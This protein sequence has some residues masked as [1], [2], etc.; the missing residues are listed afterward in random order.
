MDPDT[1]GF[2]VFVKRLIRG[3][4][5]EADARIRPGDLLVSLQDRDVRGHGLVRLREHILG[6]AGSLARMGLLSADGAFYTADVVRG[7]YRE[8]PPPAPAA[9]IQYLPPLPDQPL[10]GYYY[11]HGAPHQTAPPIQPATVAAALRCPAPPQQRPAMASAYASAGSAPRAPQAH[12]DYCA[13]PAAH[14]AFR[15]TGGPAA[16][17][18]PEASVRPHHAVSRPVEPWMQPPPR[19]PLGRPEGTPPR[20][21]A[22]PAPQRRSPGVAGERFSPG[23]RPD[24]YLEHG[25][26]Q[27]DAQVRARPAPAPR[28]A[29]SRRVSMLRR[30][31]RGGVG[32]AG[33]ARHEA[34]IA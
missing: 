33:N 19:R 23:R 13:G 29:P 30:A 16:R 14:A 27:H 8:A 20:P 6:P 11:T 10:A 17:G 1:D 32:A 21:G 25:Y 22:A 4:P 31:R 28:D 34:I 24:E 7:A 15:P 5:A 3:G 9:P 18:Y 2:I 26:T 12:G